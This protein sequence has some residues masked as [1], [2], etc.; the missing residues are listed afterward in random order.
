LAVSFNRNVPFP[1]QIG[2]AVWYSKV[3]RFRE[4]FRLAEALKRARP[5]LRS[6][7]QQLSNFSVDGFTSDRQ[8][9]GGDW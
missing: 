6:R 1:F 2:N 8:S 9:V 4:M 5:R 7:D 3:G